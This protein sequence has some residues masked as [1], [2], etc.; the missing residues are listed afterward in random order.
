MTITTQSMVDEAMELT[1]GSMVVL[2]DFLDSFET[3]LYWK[4]GMKQILKGSRSFFL[5]QNLSPTFQ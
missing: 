1:I 3:L 5:S 2:V 4:S